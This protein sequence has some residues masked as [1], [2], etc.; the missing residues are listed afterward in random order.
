MKSN[1]QRIAVLFLCVFFASLLGC[2]VNQTPSA[3]KSPGLEETVSTAT[4][5]YIYGYSLVTVDMTRRQLT[6]VAKPDATHAPMGQ[7][8]ED[9]HIPPSGDA[10]RYRSQR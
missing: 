2:G 7:N 8:L 6:N 1:C 10:H 4:D 9:S 5:A 3:A